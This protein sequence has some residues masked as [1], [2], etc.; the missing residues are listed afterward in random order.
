MYEDK[1]TL[2]GASYYN[3]KYY[4]NPDFELLP[5]DVKNEL[6]AMCVLF[7]E[8]V[9][10]ILT[11]YF[12]EDGT[13]FFETRCDEGDLFYDDVGS[14]LKIKELQRDKADLFTA[15]ET[16]YKVFVLEETT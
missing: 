14:G 9:G 6:K 4:L 8:D 11:L 2:C 10:G 16:F 3:K 1:V 5:D 13:L 15:L 7:T 12:E